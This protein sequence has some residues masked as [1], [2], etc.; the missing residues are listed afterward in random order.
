MTARAGI[1]V[2]HV[3]R[4]YG[5]TIGHRATNCNSPFIQH[6]STPDLPPRL[7]RPSQKSH[8]VPRQL[9]GHPRDARPKRFKCFKKPKKKMVSEAIQD[10]TSKQSIKKKLPSYLMPALVAAFKVGC[11]VEIKLRRFLRPIQR[12]PRF[13]ALQ[14]AFLDDS[15]VRF[16]LDSFSIGIDNHASRCMANA[17]HLFEDLH[18]INNAGEV[19]GIG[20][21]LAIKGKGTFVFSLEEDNGK[22]HTIKIPNSLYLPG[23]K[24]CIL[25]PQHW[26]QEAVDGQTWMGNFERN[27]VLNYFFSGWVRVRVVMCY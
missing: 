8:V 20:E 17:P 22:I 14:G 5:Q 11:C 16:D 21:G 12:A 18:L 6:H 13:L 23:L 24:Q 26:A 2:L 3:S 9:R 4:V 7:P 10:N 1:H 15:A 25:S 27:C 19:N